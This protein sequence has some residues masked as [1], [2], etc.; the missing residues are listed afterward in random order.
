MDTS[1]NLLTTIMFYLT[2]YPEYYKIIEKEIDA[3]I[4]KSENFKFEDIISLK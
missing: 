1:A 4:P 3:V 2:E